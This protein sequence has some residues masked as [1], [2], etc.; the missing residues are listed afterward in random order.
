MLNFVKKRCSAEWKLLNRMRPTIPA[1]ISS[2]VR[3]VE[4]IELLSHL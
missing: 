2:A 4:L 1:S 3:R